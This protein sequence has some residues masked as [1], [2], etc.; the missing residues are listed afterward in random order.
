MR[1]KETKR[2][3]A[4]CWIV[5]EIQVVLLGTER[6]ETSDIFVNFA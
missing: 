3:Q 5:S 6:K 4:E 2:H 1:I